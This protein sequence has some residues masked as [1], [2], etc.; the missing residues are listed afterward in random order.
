[1][2]N[3]TVCGT[4]QRLSEN[5]RTDGTAS[6]TMPTVCCEGAVSLSLI[7]SRAWTKMITCTSPSGLVPRTRVYCTGDPV[8][9]FTKAKSAA[10]AVWIFVQ[11]KSSGTPSKLTGGAKRWVK[12]FPPFVS[13]PNEVTLLSTVISEK[14]SP[15]ARV[16]DASPFPMDLSM[17]S[18]R[19]ALGAAAISTATRP[20]AR[21]GIL[22]KLPGLR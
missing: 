2:S 12:V 4:S 7:V 22:S 1:M 10:A 11:V 21:S 20:N 9:T 8:V 15:N 16:T 18:E 5:S 14:A 3:C 13:I 6:T 17:K 19:R